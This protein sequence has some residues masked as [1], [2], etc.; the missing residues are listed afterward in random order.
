MAI[1]DFPPDVLTSQ[2]AAEERSRAG[3]D[4]LVQQ[5]A[6]L[7]PGTLGKALTAFTRRDSEHK[8]Q[9]LAEVLTTVLRSHDEKIRQLY[10]AS[11]TYREFRDRDWPGLVFDAVKKAQALASPCMRSRVSC[12]SVI[13]FLTP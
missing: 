5:V 7:V 10:A 4:G 11:A 1:D 3:I 2:L 12:A 9:V 8:R 13:A 6:D